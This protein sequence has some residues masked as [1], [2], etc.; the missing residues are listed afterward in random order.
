MRECI[1]SPIQRK[2]EQ[3]AYAVK[4]HA[5]G[6]VKD[7]WQELEAD[8]FHKNIDHENKGNVNDDKNKEVEDGNTR[9]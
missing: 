6:R 4:Y 1:E 7:F 5:I 3:K 2:S 9:A 8:H